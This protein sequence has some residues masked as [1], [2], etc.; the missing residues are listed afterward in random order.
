MLELCRASFVVEIV[1]TSGFIF[2][3]D[4]EAWDTARLIVMFESES[5]KVEHKDRNGAFAC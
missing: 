1:D 2:C 4:D 3:W 5:V